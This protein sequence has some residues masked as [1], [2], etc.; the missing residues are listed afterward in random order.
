MRRLQYFEK[1]AGFKFL[2]CEAAQ[3]VEKL[4]LL[5]GLDFWQEQRFFSSHHIQSRCGV[6]IQAPT[7]HEGVFFYAV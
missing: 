3:S 1:L 7:L 4:A 6:P 2:Y 5:T